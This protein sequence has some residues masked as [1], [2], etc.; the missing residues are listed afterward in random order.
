MIKEESIS[1]R[2][3]ATE[4]S[5]SMSHKKVYKIRP[6]T[7]HINLFSTDT[8]QDINE[9]QVRTIKR[10]NESEN[11]I[12]NFSAFMKQII[13]TK[14][15]NFLSGDI[16]VI[17][18]I[19][20]KY[21]KINIS[22]VKEIDRLSIKINSDFGLL[23]QFSEYLPKLRELKLNYSVISSIS[24]IGTNFKNLKILQICNC[25]LKD[26]SGKHILF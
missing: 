16:K 5:F 11:I 3:G 20:S 8:S 13:E 9:I 6:Q 2:G 4:R 21:L 17:E 26:L 12:K 22:E 1:P 14:N 23:N 19:I 24:D 25:N 7:P 18:F 15:E 10:G